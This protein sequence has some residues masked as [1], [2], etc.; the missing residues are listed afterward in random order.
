MMIVSWLAAVAAWGDARGLWGDARGLWAVSRT[1]EE[2]HA[3]SQPPRSPEHRQLARSD[4]RLAGSDQRRLARSDHMNWKGKLDLKPGSASTSWVYI[5]IPKAAG[6]SF[7]KDS[8]N[9]M[10]KGCHL[11][12]SHEKAAHHQVVTSLLRRSRAQVVIFLRAPIKLMYSQFLMC[13]CHAN[14]RFDKLRYGKCASKAFGFERWVDHHLSE[15]AKAKA[16]PTAAAKDGRRLGRADAGRAGD[17]NAPGNRTQTRAS[18][19]VEAAMVDTQACYVPTN[20]QARFVVTA[21]GA[22]G[23]KRS[24]LRIAGLA[25]KAIVGLDTFAFVGVTDLYTDSMAL[26][27]AASARLIAFWPTRL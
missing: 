13:K 15:L 6:V 26:P 20:M 23:T 25:D 4:R 19:E 12:G 8:P 18:K 10:C 11:Q 3:A 2:A 21:S 1:S 9:H 7:M 24:D 16:A 14:K 22:Y 5:H 17:R 27:E